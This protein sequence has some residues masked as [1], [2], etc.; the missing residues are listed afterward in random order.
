[1]IWWS[2]QTTKPG[3]VTKHWIDNDD[4]E[5]VLYNDWPMKG[6]KPYFKPQPLSEVL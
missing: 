3:L 4:D 1:M 6:V 2:K 5:S